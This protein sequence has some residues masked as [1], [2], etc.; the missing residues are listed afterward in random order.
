MALDDTLI[1]AMCEYLVQENDCDP[2]GD[3]AIKF[4]KVGLLQASPEDTPAVITLHIVDP[5]SEEKHSKR[6]SDQEREGGGSRRQ[7]FGG[8]MELGGGELQMHA[9]TAQ[10][11]YFMTRE[12]FGQ[13]D[14][15]KNADGVFTW[16]RRKIRGVT[17]VTLGIDP[18]IDGESFVQLVVDDFRMAESG[19][20]PASYIW[21]GTVWFSVLVHAE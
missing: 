9:F 12:S 10:M 13:D 8:Y 2:P 17:P 16:L 19:G 11:S 7:I 3:G 21:R 4:I 18:E 20:P 6:I 15:R 14:A 5:K 1:T